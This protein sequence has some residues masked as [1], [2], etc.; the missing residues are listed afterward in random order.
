MDRPNRYIY[1]GLF[2]ISCN[3]LISEILLTRIFS[4]CLWYHFAFFVISIAM[5]GL[6]LGGICVQLFSSKFKSG[7][8][9]TQLA[10]F[11]FMLAISTI[12]A[13]LL[14]FKTLIPHEIFHT[15]SGKT[16]A[17]LSVAFL[18]S[19]LPFFFGGVITSLLFRNYSAYISKL[20]F[21]DLTGASLGCFLTIP[22]IETFG[23]STA[24]LLNASMACLGALF[25]LR[26]SSAKLDARL[27]RR[28]GI[29][30]ILFV[31][32]ALFNMATSAFDLRYAKGRD[33]SQDEFSK[34]NSISRI[35]V[36]KPLDDDRASWIAKNI[37]G[38]S[39]NFKDKYPITRMINIDADAGTYLTNFHDD[40]DAVSYVRYDPPSLVYRMK[41]A[42]ETLIIGAGGGKD[43]L[44]ALSFGAK[45]VTA[46]ELNPII[47][48]DIMLGRYR[49][50]SGN[51]Y[52][53]P[54]VKAVADEGRSFIASSKEKFDIIQLAYVDTSAA[55]SGG[56]YVLAENNLYT[57]ES[58]KQF[59]NHLN[60]D[61]IFTV[62]WVDV[63]GLAGS[64]RLISVGI[65]ALEGLGIRDIGQNI[66]VVSYAP[67]PNWVI[68]NILLKPA[69]FS[70]QEQEIILAACK[71]LG[72]EATY[73]PMHEGSSIAISDVRSYKDFVKAL[74][75]NKEDRDIVFSL[76]ALNVKA[77]T[78]DNPFFYYQTN[79]KDF[80][81]TIKVN[82]AASYIV[83]TSGTVVLIRVLL[84]GF[85]LADQE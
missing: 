51:L 24:V 73:I 21:A 60:A 55:T 13:P 11:A 45:H 69:P 29:F 12:I 78:D 83:Y 17:F 48:K 38:V 52:S 62:C 66:M 43:V 15:F 42:P 2:I 39:K 54:K 32:L 31:S 85:F 30:F 57:V 6:G 64:T 46:V 25:F 14:L 23:A 19:S 74:I 61:G 8:N 10:I 22:L 36:T 33:R 40:L 68:Q 84:V 63:P 37:W 26:G 70:R 81:K 65:A 49:D 79:P 59:L 3:L 16:T 44:A 58:F 75:Q 80:F 41:V 34:W 76:F 50:F 1:A 20:Y 71:D 27:V 18:L 7:L 47:V 56:A 82:Q 53:H 77:T 5:F 72:F 28:F 67:R 9:A 4:V 35:S